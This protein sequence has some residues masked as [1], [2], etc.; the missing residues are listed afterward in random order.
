[1]STDQILIFV[2]LSATLVLFAWG[3]WRYDIVALTARQQC[4]YL[5]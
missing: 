4:F 5:A 3:K 2:I 1:M